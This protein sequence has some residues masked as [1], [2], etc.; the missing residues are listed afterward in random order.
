MSKDEAIDLAYQIKTE[1]HMKAVEVYQLGNNEYACRL[2]RFFFVWNL[3]N[4]L[5]VENKLPARG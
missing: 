4:W 3:D 5:E 2:W 1:K